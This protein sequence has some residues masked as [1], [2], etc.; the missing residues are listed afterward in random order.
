MIPH[1][2][3]SYNEH[4]SRPAIRAVDGSGLDAKTGLR[5]GTDPDTEFMTGPRRTSAATPL[6]PGAVP[7]EHWVAFE[8]DKVYPLGE[9]WIWNQG[10]AVFHTGSPANLPHDL[11]SPVMHH[12]LPGG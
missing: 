9:M 3:E 7:G 12:R 5:H 6:H 4:P 11:P 1:I 8:F 2:G 10:E